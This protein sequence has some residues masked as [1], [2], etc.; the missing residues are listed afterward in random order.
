MYGIKGLLRAVIRIVAEII[1][2]LILHLPDTL[3][4]FLNW[5]GKKLRIKILIL[6]H[7]RK[8]SFIS[9]GDLDKAIN[10]ARNVF[11][12]NF[13][14]SL[15]PYGDREP[16]AEMLVAVPPHEALYTR[17]GSGALGDEFEIPGSFFASNLKAPIYPVTVF[18]VIDIKGANGCS[19]GPMT[20]YVTLDQGGAK[21]A[22]ILA[23]ELAHAC[24]L[25]HLTD[26]N[27]LLWN[28]S[29]RGDKIRWWQ[30]NIF[31]SSRHVTYW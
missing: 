4:G 7:D 6:S 2:R 20:D 21:D 26:K 24:G 25:W 22:S 11:K 27:N 10:Y 12:K 9:P 19:L 8:N 29:N 23:H 1:Y 31:R 28:K 17:G 13:N 30:R 3:F 16:I 14:V 5:P 18:V 15:L